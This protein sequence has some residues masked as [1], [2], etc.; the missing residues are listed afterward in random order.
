[1]KRYIYNAESD[2]LPIATVRHSL[3]SLQ[4][5]EDSSPAAVQENR[6]TIPHM[7]SHRVS[8]GVPIPVRIYAS[9]SPSTQ[10]DKYLF[11]V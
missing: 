9:I 5:L 4:S 10:I 7:S 11:P 2:L 6:P 8:P 3:N 1:M